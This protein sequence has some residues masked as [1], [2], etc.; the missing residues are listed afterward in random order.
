MKLSP[1]HIIL[2]FI[3][4]SLAACG[5]RQKTTE[6]DH[7]LDSIEARNKAQ[8]IGYIIQ[9][10]PEVDLSNYKKDREGFIHIF[11]GENFDGWRG[12]GKDIMPEAWT[13]EDDAIKINGSG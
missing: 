9:S 3:A 2:I 5:N 8:R 1:Y 11:N 7:P 6:T 13:I 10:K 4:S 12:Y